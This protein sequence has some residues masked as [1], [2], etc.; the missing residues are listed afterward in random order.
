MRQGGTRWFR[1]IAGW[2]VGLGFVLGSRPVLA[3]GTPAGTAIDNVADVT[4]TIGGST[5]TLRTL[6]A[7]IVVNELLDV[8]AVALTP[9]VAVQPGDTQRVVAIRLVNT[10]NGSEAYSLALDAALTGDQFD[11]LPRSPALY[12]DSD[13]SG[14]LTAADQAYV[15]GSNDPVLAPDAAR[16]VFAVFDIPPG[17]PDTSRG[18]VQL[19]VRAL[20]GTGAPGTVFAGR[21]D[22]GVD[23]LVGLSGA[24]AVVSAGFVVSGYDVA[25]VKTAT[26]LDP[27]GGTRPEPGA[28]ISYEI[29][30]TVTGT[31][32][33][34][35]LLVSDPIPAATTYLPGSLTLD[36]A[37]LTDAADGD[38]GALR[39]SAPTRIEVALGTVAAGTTHRIRFTVTVD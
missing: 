30:A 28:R 17:L 15:P 32:A 35:S 37:P 18:R 31:G 38:A 39:T 13:G 10:G 24:S 33:A 3:G 19:T 14:T 36:G 1:A 20:T 23:A 21:G 12:I 16:V 26:V 2:V 29:A 9:T 7:R 34:S 8:S 11:P 27:A 5:S 6:P 22:A 4:F 25:L